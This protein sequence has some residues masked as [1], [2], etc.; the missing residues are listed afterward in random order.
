VL[1]AQKTL[2]DPRAAL[3][4]PTPVPSTVAGLVALSHA[5]VRTA[6]L[7][8]PGFETTDYRV[9]A[10]LLA[11]RRMSD[12]DIHLVLADPVDRSR[13]MI[14]ELPDP[15]CRDVAQSLFRRS[16][17]GAR[18]AFVS[19]CGLPPKNRYAHLAGTATLDGVG[20][21]DEPHHHRLPGEA[22]NNVELHPLLGFRAPRCTRL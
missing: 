3:V 17:A 21:F 22:A 7:R 18:G 4:D 16:M 13:R 6:S 14:A 15:G 11:A 12:R 9:T 10:R 19:A 2:S 20:F 5:R 1:W 8:T